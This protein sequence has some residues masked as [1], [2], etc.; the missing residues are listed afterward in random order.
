M[1]HCI[2]T[3]TKK[4]LG[5]VTLVRT[6]VAEGAALLAAE[7]QALGEAG[8]D[9]RRL[10]MARLVVEH[11]MKEASPPSLA[12]RKW[13]EEAIDL[14]LSDAPVSLAVATRLVQA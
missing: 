3:K 14:L 2:L 6:A 10:L 1:N 7:G 5:D 9:A 4:Q 8:G 13:E 12:A 11:R